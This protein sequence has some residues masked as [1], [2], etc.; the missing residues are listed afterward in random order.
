[1][2]HEDLNVGKCTWLS[3]V[4]VY[5]MWVLVLAL[6][7]WVLLVSRDAIVGVASLVFVQVSSA[8]AWRI[9]AVEKYYVL[10]AGFV[11]LGLMVFSELYFR[12]GV[13]RGR[14]IPRIAR[15]LGAELLALSVFDA[16]LFVTQGL[17]AEAWLRWLI[18]GS[19]LAFGVIC[20]VIAR[21]SPRV[22]SDVQA[23][24]PD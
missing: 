3:Y 21:P 23:G 10:G 24:D 5:V 2:T 4:L 13:R 16:I 9:S 15:F 17:P 14:L 7:I 1:M 12:N 18:L 20:L 11:W 19:E 22:I 8:R 6:G